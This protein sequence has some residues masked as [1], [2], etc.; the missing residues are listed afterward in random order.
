MN[1]QNGF[2]Q[3]SLPNVVVNCTILG[4]NNEGLK[5][6]IL[7]FRNSQLFGLPAGLIN[8][9]EDLDFSAHR[10]LKET[11]GLQNL[12]L[13]NFATFGNA[14]RV[15]KNQIKEL[16]TNLNVPFDKAHF[17]FQR[18]VSVGYLA[19]VDIQKVSLSP[20]AFTD[21]LEWYD[22]DKIPSLVHDHKFI[23]DTALK[24]LKKNIY[25]TPVIQFLMPETFTMKELQHLYE[26]I[27]NEKLVRT[28]FQRWMLSKEILERLD[29][30][31]TGKAHKA[32]YQYSFKK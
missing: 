19:L 3:G 10:V 12:Y 23:L 26:R 30:L 22:I 18:F 27:L 1:I 4:F 31:Y 21:K 8:E 28:N 5:V 16:L 24:Y 20:D 32:P 29:K 15:N 13:E 6:L 2:A 17:L 11:T 7:K 9:D 25:D 14:D